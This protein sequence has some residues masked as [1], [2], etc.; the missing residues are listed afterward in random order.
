LGDRAFD[1]IAT[2]IATNQGAPV[3]LSSVPV[4]QY[5][6]QQVA[7]G[8]GLIVDDTVA[9]DAAQIL[10][11]VVQYI[12]AIPNDGSSNYLDQVARADVVA[13]GTIAPKLAMVGS[14]GADIATLL[15][16]YT[17]SALADLISGAAA[18]TLY[19]GGATLSIGQ[20][21]EQAVG[22]GD[23]SNF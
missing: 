20:A 5:L 2:A 11:G 16:D 12:G 21:V 19:G 14:G 4:L 23:A 3:V 9:S 15:A 22:V 8:A 17:G 6:I 13:T 18:G 10:A 1:A 7:S